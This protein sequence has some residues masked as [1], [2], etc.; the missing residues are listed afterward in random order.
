MNMKHIPSFLFI[1]LFLLSA[2]PVLAA[3]RSAALPPPTGVQNTPEARETVQ[4]T[5]NKSS[6][7]KEFSA[8]D[9]NKDVQVRIFKRKNGATVEEYSLHGRVY[10]I[11]VSPA[12]GTPPYYLYDNNGDG[13]FE[14]RLPGGHKYI[15]PPEWVIKRF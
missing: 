2:F 6:L 3:D 15:N 8:P 13:K 12:I 7:G 9:T 10:M 1:S 4:P 5:E 11:K 14:R